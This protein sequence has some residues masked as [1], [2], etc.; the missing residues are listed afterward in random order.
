[1]NEKE[2]W[3]E[4]ENMVL[5]SF[6]LL[7]ALLI[8]FAGTVMVVEQITESNTIDKALDLLY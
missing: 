1:M 2:R 4:H 8:L 7:V 6:L 5:F 3:W